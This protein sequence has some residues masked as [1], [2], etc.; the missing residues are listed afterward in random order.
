MMQPQSTATAVIVLCDLVYVTVG[1]CVYP[2]E[3]VSK[4]SIAP[5]LAYFA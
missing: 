2:L 5:M 4:S 3:A 1:I